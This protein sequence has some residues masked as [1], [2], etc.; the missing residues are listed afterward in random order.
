MELRSF[1]AAP[2]FKARVFPFLRRN[3]AQNCLGLG[4]LD[5]LVNRPEVYPK[6][7]LW[8]VTDSS[9]H[10]VGAAWMMPPH[11]IGLTDMPDH[12]LELLIDAAMDLPD[13]PR[14]VVGPKPQADRFRDLWIKRVGAHLKSTMEQRIYQVTDVAMPFTVQGQMRVAGESDRGRLEK[15][16]L[17]FSTDCGLSND[18]DQAKAATDVAIKMK[19]RYF[20]IVNDVP[21]SMAGVSGP[22][23]SGIRVSWVY[24]PD[25]LR[26]HGYGSAVVAAL[27]QKMLSEGRKFCF[28]YT[29]LANPTSNS[30]YQKLGYRPVCDSAHHSFRGI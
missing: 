23:P 17:G 4:I 11:P 13:C 2:E 5:T 22:T 12:A 28:L 25:E 18:P 27:S 21:V 30:I 8:A 9:S 10:V 3:E 14:S 6:A 20:W 16:S 19:S 26:G 29:D 7:Y 24:T 1:D 15:W